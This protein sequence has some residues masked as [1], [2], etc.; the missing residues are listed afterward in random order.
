[1]NFYERRPMFK[2][3]QFDGTT[4]SIN[5]MNKICTVQNFML[6]T[7]GGECTVQIELYEFPRDPEKI[8]LQSG[9]WLV[10]KPCGEVCVISDREMCGRFEP[11]SGL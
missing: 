10:L 1:M 5:S 8:T 3:V 4:Q 11:V 7:R 6:M 2:A 9:D